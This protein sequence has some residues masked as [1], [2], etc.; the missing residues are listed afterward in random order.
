MLLDLDLGLFFWLAFIALS[1]I[2]VFLFVFE[3][4]RV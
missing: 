4:L 3:I 1:G 2:F